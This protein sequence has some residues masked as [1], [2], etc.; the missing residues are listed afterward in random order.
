MKRILA[1]MTA[2]L[3]VASMMAV[4][5]FAAD[6][7][8]TVCD[9]SE[10]HGG[11]KV[12]I[13]TYYFV[14]TD[15]DGTEYRLDDSL[16][17]DYYSKVTPTWKK[18][19]SM[20]EQVYYNDGDSY[21]TLVIKAGINTSVSKNIIG[22]LKIRDT[23]ARRN[24]VCKI[25]EGDLVVKGID[26]K[27]N[28]YEDGDKEFSLPWDYQT[29]KVRF[30]TDD[31]AK[32]GTFTAEFD[33]DEG[34]HIAKFVTKVVD[35]S[36][37]YLGFNETENIALMK[38][39]PDANMRFINWTRPKFELKGKLSIYMESDEYIYG[40][41]TDDTLYRL[42]GTWDSDNDA[43]VISTDTL[44]S[45][46]ISDTQLVKTGSSGGATT[47]PP[48][49]SSTAPK[50][51]STTPKPSSSVAPPPSSSVAPP[52]SSSVAPPPTSSPPAQE[53]SRS[54]PAPESSEPPDVG[55]ADPDPQPS[56]PASTTPD[57][58]DDED[59]DDED[60]DEDEKKGFPIIPVLLGVLILVVVVCTIVVLGNQGGGRQRKKRFDD[61][62]D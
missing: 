62:D 2:A 48:P 11:E 3:I 13:D 60:E 8:G 19:G 54:E 14:Y 9:P 34:D 46:V 18:N 32:Y 27:E 57:D 22:Q 15:K 38:K 7:E 1:M 4:T 50:P 36:A 52:P 28:M 21:V 53:S 37:L 10:V 49:A 23:E 45:Y 61:W 6:D 58:D 43:Y 39:F 55:G 29:K 26:E 17:V 20:V 42:G 56:R 5:A 59:E 12:T 16:D 51:S 47:T 31:G 35:Q 33:N 25:E 41:N 44:G 40:I 30:V 24:Y